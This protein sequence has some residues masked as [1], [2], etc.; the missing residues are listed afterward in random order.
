M[1]GYEDLIEKYPDSIIQKLRQGYENEN[2]NENV[3]RIQN[4]ERNNYFIQKQ[5]VEL[6]GL[7]NTCENILSLIDE[8][9]LKEKSKV[10][11]ITHENKVEI[12][13]CCNN[14]CNL[15]TFYYSTGRP[16]FDPCMRYCDCEWQIINKILFLM[17]IKNMPISQ[18]LLF[19]LL[20]CR[21][22]VLQKVG[23]EKRAD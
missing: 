22:N 8:K 20:R 10:L 12:E 5:L 11:A 17:T 18:L 23:Y 13:Q 21:I 16:C 19:D 6:L 1:K 14:P 2:K 7:I 3:S 4:I 15:D 9:A